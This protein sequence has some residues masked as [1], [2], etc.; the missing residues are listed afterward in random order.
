MDYQGLIM[1]NFEPQDF[2]ECNLSD[3]QFL[4]DDGFLLSSAVNNDREMFKTFGD[5][6]LQYEFGKRHRTI[7]LSI[8]SREGIPIGVA[9]YY[10]NYPPVF[11]ST[12][13]LKVVP[14]SLFLEHIMPLDKDLAFWMLWNI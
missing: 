5:Y 13:S 7:N 6:T 8:Y 2:V 1:A 4:D 14:K 9:E 12:K 11:R 10:P 3:K